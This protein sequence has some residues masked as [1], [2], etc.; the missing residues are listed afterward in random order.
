MHRPHPKRLGF[1][2]SWVE[3]RNLHF[4]KRPQES[5]KHMS[6]EN[7]LQDMKHQSLDI[8]SECVL[9]QQTPMGSIFSRF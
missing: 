9:M 1:S 2:T 4:N 7:A 6:I 3:P 5:L 8:Y